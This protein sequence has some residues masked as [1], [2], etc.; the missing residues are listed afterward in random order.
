MRAKYPIYFKVYISFDQADEV[1]AFAKKKSWSISKLI[2]ESVKKYIGIDS[3]P[4]K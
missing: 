3:K 2:R 4:K 1:E